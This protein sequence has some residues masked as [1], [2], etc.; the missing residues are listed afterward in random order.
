LLDRI[1]R[2]LEHFDDAG[3]DAFYITDPANRFYLSGFSGT[4][5]ALLL[6]RKQYC[7]LTDFRYTEQAASESP[8]YKIIEVPGSYNMVLA[9]FLKENNLFRLGCE[10]DHLTYNQ[11][12]DLQKMLPGIELKPGSG[13]VE[14][15]RICKDDSEI[16]HIE[17][18]VC[19]ADQAFARVLAAVKTGVIER[20]IALQLEY[21]MRQSGADGV[22]FQFIVASGSRSALPHGVASMK[23][24]HSG[25]LVTFDFGAVYRGYNSDITRTVVMGQPEPRQRE[26]YEIVLEAQMSAISA[27][28]A[29]VRASAVDQAARDVIEKKGYGRCFGHSTGHGLGLNIHENPRLSAKD[30]TI[31]RPGMVVTVEPGIYLPGWGG[32]RIEDTV[33]VEDNGCRILTRS[34]KDKLVSL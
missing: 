32:V 13:M 26:I 21:I 11:F 30:E 8:D 18:A 29:G 23:T 22:A 12:S 16:K 1:K 17:E 7:L 28:K 14:Q 3:L 10:G 4:T 15:L 2:L 6:T 25:D 31:L 5:G 24:I 20:E 34:P 19:L 33:V 27:I 9:E